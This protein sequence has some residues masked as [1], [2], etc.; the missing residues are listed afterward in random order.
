MK[1]GREIALQVLK[2]VDE[3]GAYAN[4]ALSHILEQY[5]PA[6]LDRRF[7]TELVYGTIKARNTLDW[8]IEKF[9]SRPLAKMTVWVRNVL[10][11]GVY[12]LWY[13]ERV[14]P[15]A[16][17]NEAV[18]LTKRYGHQGTAKF[19]NG[20]LRTVARQKADIRFPSLEED[21]VQH[22]ALQFS[23]PAWMVECWLARF[24]REETIRLC[25]ANNETPR[26][27]VRT[28]TLKITRAA[29]KAA[30]EKEGLLVEESHWAPEGLML[31]GFSALGQLAALQEGLF[32]VQD[33]SSML[34]AH[35][36]DPQ[37]GEFIIDACGAPGGKTTH[38]A[39]KMHNEGRIFSLDIHAHK[40]RLIT[41]NCRR[42]GIDIVE[43]EAMDARRMHEHMRGQADRVLV[44]APCSGLGVL[45]RKPDARWRKTPEMLRDLPK[46]Q[47]EIL[48]SA[49]QCVKPG[50][51]LVYSTCTIEAEE[52][53]AVIRCFL[54]A[55]PAFSLEPTGK[56]LPVARQEEMVRLFPQ[57]DG[58]D[59]FF[60]A[61]MKRTENA[62]A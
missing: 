9:S 29:L 4:I 6:P 13:L 23:H 21:P 16:A 28:N 25:Q 35:V 50:G 19:V 20:V 41:E 45:R 53:E 12:Q 43:T 44:D 39:Q 27:S 38:F 46:L 14:P 3:N 47:Q 30:L 32:Q 58:I 48:A 42:L 2:E 31:D 60:I 59:G 40:L 54:Q 61:R 7:I 5:R 11:M 56:F 18:N 17:C 24:G 51:I 55:N 10:R 52:N 1:T 15:S 26:L 36:L 57:R 33:E 8:I 49:A 22:I 37:P 34:V 62:G